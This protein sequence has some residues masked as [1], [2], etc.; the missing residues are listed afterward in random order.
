MTTN[1]ARALMLATTVMAGLS[2][3]AP[4][5]AQTT[6]QQAPATSSPEA[7][8][9][10]A[11]VIIVTGSR[12][13]KA[14]FESVY[15]AISITSAS[16]EARG[17]T[18]VL[19]MLNT[20]PATGIGATPVGAQGGFGA[21]ASFVNL[22]DLGSQRTLTL[23][24]SRRFVG[25]NQATLFGQAGSGLQV[26]L[27]VL[28]TA[29]IDK[30]EVIS[31]GG[32]PVY[33]ADAV[34]GTINVILKRQFEGYE[35]DV[36]YSGY[37]VGAGNFGRARVTAGKNFLD[38]KLNLAASFEYSEAD[39]FDANNS[40]RL[41][42]Q[43]AFVA[44]PVNSAP[45]TSAAEPNGVFDNYLIRN[46][47]LPS[48]TT[49][50]A[51]F[52]T[53]AAPTYLTAADR[54]FLL[55]NPSVNPA[56]ALTTTSNVASR[57]ATA[58]EIAAGA[59]TRVAVPLLFAPGGNIVPMNLGL[60][61]ADQVLNSQFAIGGDGVGL[62]EFTSAQTTLKRELFNA[63][64]S[65]KHAD[66]LRVS[67]E[68]LYSRVQGTELTNQ[69]GF[70]SNLFGG[71]SV[72]LGFQTD[73]PFLNDQARSV[74]TDP[75]LNLSAA[76][77][78]TRTLTSFTTPNVW[79]GCLTP[80]M[81]TDIAAGCPTAAAGT[82]TFFT[83]RIQKDIIGLAPSLSDG[84]TSRIVIA[85]EGDFDFAD[86]EFNYDISYGKGT[87][88]SDSTNTSI[89]QARFAAARDAIRNASGAI[90]CRVNSSNAAEK[91][92]ARFWF[93]YTNVAP[94]SGTTA[95]EPNSPAPAA[96][97][98]RRGVNDP[99]RTSEA[100]LDACQP[101][102]TFGLGSPSAEAQ[103][104]VG[105]T[106]TANAKNEQE[107]FE[108]NFAGTVVKLPAGNLSMAV[109]YQWRKE[110]GEFTTSE[111]ARIGTARSAGIAQTFGEY[112][113]SEYYVELKA[114]IFG[115]DF[116]FPG[117]R[118]LELNG[119]YRSIDNS[120]NGEDNSWTYGLIYSPFEDL[121]FRG[122][123]TRAIRSPSL[124]ELNL[125]SSDSFATAADPCDS[126]LINSGAVPAI[127]RA[128]CVAEATARGFAGLPAFISNVR[129]ATV[130]GVN[131][132]NPDLTNEIA[133]SFT[134]GFVFQGRNL[135]GKPSIAVDY[136]NIKLTN[137]IENFGLVALMNSCYD[138]PLGNTAACARFIRGPDFQIVLGSVTD[139]AFR[140]GFINAGFRN[141]DGINVTFDWGF[142]INK[143]AT[144][145]TADLGKI[146][147]R[148]VYS[149]VDTLEVSVLGTG[150][151]LDIQDSEVSRPTSEFQL[152]TTY[153]YKK[154]T[155]NLVWAHQSAA[156]FD[157]QFSL[158][159]REQQKVE[160]YDLFNLALSYD[161]ND[162]FTVRFITNNLFDVEAP[163][164]SA[165]FAYDQFG[166]S[167]SF[168]VRATF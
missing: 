76:S 48:L 109:G 61:A 3:T 95:F 21:G 161:I 118:E 86:R 128:N 20:L 101:I 39:G 93:R 19:D 132:G 145:Y 89:S 140:A 126:T 134:Y 135:F 144:E 152:T 32:A 113:S 97:F 88:D 70:N 87:S 111:D 47:R 108:A 155:A 69:A 7:E 60:I 24:N 139:P 79:G 44:N 54:S 33:G 142:D 28:P 83:S 9:E 148:F 43:F 59:R 117:L 167:Y 137:S 82:R 165:S 123:K 124:V 149:Y 127:R 133:D 41:A 81:P 92:A 157:R 58:A 84:V 138:N 122:N 146:D 23:V 153:K 78:A 45:F 156:F 65:Y 13:R 49:G 2:V 154:A 74:L 25:G 15:P 163:F 160:A 56:F 164:P 30:I 27:N 80:G 22:F 31:V 38:D 141:F 115:Q 105:Q 52:L 159:N 4:V 29:F 37:E 100:Q 147:F 103:A 73:N 104:Y 151:D 46:R 18:N 166:R 106:L 168:G 136:V 110:V 63:M 6:A 8:P 68:G 130:R 34:A 114:P 26:D 51:I 85:A 94:A 91:T 64:G 67:F 162:N 112:T 10:K 42:A 107:F 55:A 125:P 72:A 90:V 120:I 119:A 116:Q 75:N 129:F 53:G 102:N 62:A 5:F 150:T 98:F 99:I 143:L 14:E 66:W 12:I 35:A 71:V 50:G 158:E 16:V 17:I 121:T 131:L 1:S 36:Q 96:G 77:A 57:P 40:P 11:E